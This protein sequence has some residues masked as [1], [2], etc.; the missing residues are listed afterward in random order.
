MF[1]TNYNIQQGSFN[2]CWLIS[3]VDS[4]VHSNPTLAKKVK[5]IQNVYVYRNKTYKLQDEPLRRSS[6][7]IKFIREFICGNEYAQVTTNKSDSVQWIER[8]EELYVRIQLRKPTGI[9]STDDYS[10]LFGSGRSPLVTFT[11]LEDILY[12]PET[13]KY[14]IEVDTR[15]KF[16]ITTDEV[17]VFHG[18]YLEA[19]NFLNK[20]DYKYRYGYFA[21]SQLTKNLVPSHAYAVYDINETGIVIRNPYG[22]DDREYLYDQNDGLIVLPSDDIFDILHIQICFGKK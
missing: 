20:I 14:I 17:V 15:K 5:S 12:L 8:I 2:D 1:R 9:L 16:T 13:I 21:T 10:N 18:N 7:I 22:Y 3:S 11:E 6:S 4:I 19:V